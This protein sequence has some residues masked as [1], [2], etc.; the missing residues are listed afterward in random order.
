MRYFAKEFLYERVTKAKTDSRTIFRVIGATARS[1]RRGRT[2][3]RADYRKCKKNGCKIIQFPQIKDKEDI[4]GDTETLLEE[5]KKT[6]DRGD[7]LEELKN[8]YVQGILKFTNQ[9]ISKMPKELKKHF[10]TGGVIVHARKKENGVIELRCQIQK[11]KIAVSSKSLDIAKQKFIEA[12]N[13]AFTESPEP[14]TVNKKIALTDYMFKWLETVK[15]PYVKP[16]TYK[17]YI[18]TLETYIKPQFGTNEL[19]S[20]KGFE[21]QSFINGFTEAKKFRTAKKLYQLLAAVFDYAVTDEIIMKSPMQRITVPRYE[22]EHG[23]PVT[24]QEEKY[25]IECLLLGGSIYAQAYAFLMY[26]GLRRSELASAE[27]VDGWIIITTSKQRKG[28]KVKLRSLPIP[29]MLQK[30]LSHI[31]FDKI[32]KLT[33]A[34]LTKHIKDFFPNHHAHDLRHTFVTRCQECGIQRELVSLWVGHTA[35][36]STTTLVYTHLEQN[37]E[38]QIEEM[39]KFDYLL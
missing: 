30:V 2:R 20:I 39:K 16:I 4:T 7:K 33:P 19:A 34:M 9:E 29:P 37:K 22:Q 3:V 5:M 25:L 36:S 23:I 8:S 15:K 13:K 21:I 32:K 10:K 1:N 18:Y 27:I 35:D 14:E 11:K 24:R 26:S 28:M 12:L 6:S 17:D 31:D 38:H